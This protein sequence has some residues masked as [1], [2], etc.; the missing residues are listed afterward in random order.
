[1]ACK[2]THERKHAMDANEQE[3]DGVDVIQHAHVA[4]AFLKLFVTLAEACVSSSKPSSFVEAWLRP[5][6]C[7]RPRLQEAR[8]L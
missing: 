1:M 5:E 3:L 2:T 4:K 6:A 7:A 8:R